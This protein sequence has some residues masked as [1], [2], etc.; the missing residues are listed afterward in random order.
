MLLP[1]VQTLGALSIVKYEGNGGYFGNATYKTAVSSSVMSEVPTYDSNI[2]EFKGWSTT[3]LNG[4]LSIQKASV[5]KNLELYHA[6]DA[7]PAGAKTLYAVWD[8]QAIDLDREFTITQHFIDIETMTEFRAAETYTI[9][10]GSCV[11]QVQPPYKV[12]SQNYNVVE[13]EAHVDDPYGP[14]VAL[15]D[16]IPVRDCHLYTFFRKGEPGYEELKNNDIQ[17]SGTMAV[18]YEAVLAT[19][20]FMTNDTF[21]YRYSYKDGREPEV[22]RAFTVKDCGFERDGYTFTGWK[23]THVD[24][25]GNEESKIYQPGDT[26]I[27]GT[28]DIIL[29]H[30]AGFALNDRDASGNA[31][32]VY[33][34]RYKYIDE[35][36]NLLKTEYSWTD[37]RGTFHKTETEPTGARYLYADDIT[38]LWKRS[39]LSEVLLDAQWTADPV[40]LTYD[41]NFDYGDQR[42]P[43]GNTKGAYGRTLTDLRSFYVSPI[44]TITLSHDQR[45][46]G[47]GEVIGTMPRPE[48]IGYVF[49]NW[50]WTEGADGNGKNLPVTEEDEYPY[51]TPKTL[52]ARWEP[53]DVK[54]TLDYNGAGANVETTRK[55]LA[56]Y[57]SLPNP[58]A[59]PTHGRGCGGMCPPPKFRKELGIIRHSL[60]LKLR[61]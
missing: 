27:L 19:S 36:G 45:I 4:V 52:H 42:F 10:A 2:F 54:I 31:V 56:T 25:D 7:I 32:T 55:F 28:T 35:D 47:E 14:V 57:L 11:H 26:I 6:G 41:Y 21:N 46:I 15:P 44:K 1:S 34:S 53:A 61:F 51:R 60:Y 20:G 29:Y 16:Y 24:A 22:L 58:T 23:Y 18:K 43:L 33:G 38:V 40:V 50:S 5:K 49:R 17:K 59:E 30:A 9:T 37:G 3:K 8:T 39:F 12:G 48:R 13:W